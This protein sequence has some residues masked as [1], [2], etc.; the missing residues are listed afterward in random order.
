MPLTTLCSTKAIAWKMENQCNDCSSVRQH[1]PHHQARSTPFSSHP[2]QATHNE[3]TRSLARDHSTM[4]TYPCG[5]NRSAQIA[6][7][8]S[9]ARS[10]ISEIGRTSPG[11][12]T[13]SCTRTGISR[14]VLEMDSIVLRRTESWKMGLGREH[15]T[16]ALP[17]M[18]VIGPA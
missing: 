1:K 11:S 12:E 14:Y 15:D 16:R 9:L 2:E 18:I 4:I 6:Q 8:K 13:S 17:Y 10:L 3:N 5:L 7:P